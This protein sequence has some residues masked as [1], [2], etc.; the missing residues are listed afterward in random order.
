MQLPPSSASPRTLVLCQHQPLGPLTFLAYPL[1][2]S[3]GPRQCRVCSDALARRREPG[4]QG[5]LCGHRLRLGSGHDWPAC[6]CHCCLSVLGPPT[7]TCPADTRLPPLS[8][9]LARSSAAPSRLAV[10]SRR[11][12]LVARRTDQ[13]DI[14]KVR[15]QSGDQ[16]KGMV[17]CATRILKDEGPAAFYK[18]Q[19]NRMRRSVLCW[20]GRAEGV[21]SGRGGCCSASAPRLVMVVRT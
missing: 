3:D 10:G 16:Y 17:D 14:V 19:L 5:A 20:E 11:L 15:L 2:Y 1:K 12:A 18:G 9:P 13:F 21:R 8:L 4:R 6:Q 7:P